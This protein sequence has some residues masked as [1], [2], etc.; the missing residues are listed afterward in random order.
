MLKFKLKKEGQKFTYRGHRLITVKANNDG[1]YSTCYK[2]AIQEFRLYKTLRDKLS[3]REA[4]KCKENC[5]YFKSLGK[6][7]K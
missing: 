2:C 1:Y 6:V 7:K 4:H 5:F 3:C